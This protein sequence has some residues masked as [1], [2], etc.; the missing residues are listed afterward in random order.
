MNVINKREGHSEIRHL[1]DNVN[2]AANKLNK[3]YCDVGFMPLS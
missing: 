2:D 1:D 3:G